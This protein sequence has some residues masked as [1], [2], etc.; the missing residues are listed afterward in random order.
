[1]V[2]KRRTVG[3]PTGR[4]TWVRIERRSAE[5][6]PVWGWNGTE[7]AERLTGIAKPRWLGSLVWP[8]PGDPSVW[9][10][11]DETA[12]LP[13]APVIPAGVLTDD[14]R[15][16]ESWWAQFHASL[17][18]MSALDTAETTVRVA[19]SD[20]VPVTVRHVA[21]VIASICDAEPRIR[22]WAVAH[23][24]LGWPNITGPACCLFDWEDWGAAPAGM[25][26]ACLWAASLAVPS[27]A[28]RIHSERPE[29]A[30]PTGVTMMLYYAAKL[31]CDGHPEDPR[32]PLARQEAKRLVAQL[33]R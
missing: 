30:D 11:A 9:W 2:R 6:V 3:L 28:D 14:P 10:R 4:D 32:M 12:L 7:T 5:R 24:D 18:A 8:D 33:Q 17:D 31:L 19:V 13:D 23:A 27:L 20:T 26:A 22:R 25:D 21:E 15:L 29:L 16:P 1:M